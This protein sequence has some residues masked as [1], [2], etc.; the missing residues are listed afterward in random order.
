[1]TPDPLP[2]GVGYLSPAIGK[3][4]TS[5]MIENA[6]LVLQGPPTI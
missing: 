2:V 1:M 6:F 3:R 4:G 5:T